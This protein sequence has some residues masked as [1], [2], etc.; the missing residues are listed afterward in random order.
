[1]ESEEFDLVPPSAAALTESLRG[2][3]YSLPAAIADIIDNSISAGAATVWLTFRWRNRQPT[4]SVRDDGKGMSEEE[5]AEAMRLGG[6]G[7]ARP[8][9]PSDLG[10]FG[11]GLKT[12]SFSQC[13]RLTVASWRTGSHPNFRRWDLDHIGSGSRDWQL[14]KAPA[15]GSEG[16]FEG[17]AT[18]PSG[19]IVLWEILDRLV[20]DDTIEVS[21]F[22]EAV[23]RLE[24]HLAMVFQRFL[25]GL[26]P[27]LR[28]YING[29][30]DAHRVRSWDP[31]MA[32]HPST[33][34]R[35]VERIPTRAGIVAVQGFVLPHKDRLTPKESEQF[36]GAGG[37]AAQQGFYV[38]RNGRLLTAG[39]W[40]GLGS[41]RRWTQEEAY[42]LA[43]IR[44]DIPNTADTDWKIDIR[45]SIARPPMYLRGRLRA[46][47]EDA[48]HI[49]RQI[50]AHRGSYGPR[51]VV[52][53]LKRMWL[54]VEGAHGVSYR[55]N[56]SH[57]AIQDVLAMASRD[58]STLEA[59]LR[60]IEETV[61]VQRIWLDATDRGDV[62]GEAFDG[63]AE[64]DAADVL[65]TLYKHLRARV[66]MTAAAARDHLS[67][68]EPFNQ[69]PALVAALPDTLQEPES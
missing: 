49:A 56:R 3:G 50:F 62:V 65:L 61:P 1:M 57:P 21:V 34:R 25:E 39:G 46:L 16:L 2:V 35:P 5:L 60:L 52:V 30:S 53:D 63:K 40:L 24:E 10:R 31:F 45:K 15:I 59:A 23:E 66:G 18:T 44:V 41:P 14:L 8:R 27:A 68:T 12:A 9:S 19:T 42:K 51:P 29:A 20:D 69:L 58:V 26:A 7:R 54:V 48:R 55:V 67:K 13:R 11:L 33:I 36:A 4:V 38:Y 37:W 28:I 32:D 22:L 43:R 6:L 64:S 47:A 17:L